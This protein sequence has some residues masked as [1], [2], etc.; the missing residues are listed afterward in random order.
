[1]HYG[2]LSNTRQTT[3]GYALRFYYCEK[4]MGKNWE[5]IGKFLQANSFII[6]QTMGNKKILR[7]VCSFLYYSKI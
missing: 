1:M 6:N 7:Y 2:P 4:E 5:K 3:T